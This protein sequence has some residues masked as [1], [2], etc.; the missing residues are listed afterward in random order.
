M[1][2]YGHLKVIKHGDNPISVEGRMGLDV[3]PGFTRER[4][5][6]TLRAIGDL[7]ETRAREGAPNEKALA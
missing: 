2:V 1:E 3:P 5:E 7:L 6:T 4:W